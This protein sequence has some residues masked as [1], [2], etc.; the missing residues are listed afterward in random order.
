M[1]DTLLTRVLAKNDATA[2]AWPSGSGITELLS[3]GIGGNYSAEDSSTAVPDG[4]HLGNSDAWFAAPF[5]NETSGGI[6]YY[7]TL[8]F[9]PRVGHVPQLN[10]SVSSLSKRKFQL[11]DG[12]DYTNPVGRLGLGPGHHADKRDSILDQLESDGAIASNTFSLHMGS[13]LLNQSASLIFG[14]YEKNRAL[15]PVGSF[16]MNHGFPMILLRD[17]FLGTAVG[18]TVFENETISVYH[19]IG[20]DKRAALVS[21]GSKL[22]LGATVAGPNP[23][24][25]YIYLPWGTCEAAAKHLP[26]T[27]DDSLGLYLWNVEDPRYNRT[28]GS[29]AYMGFTL[30]D[31][32]AANIT[33]KVP[34]QLLNLTLTPP[35]VE[36]P[37]KYLPCRPTRTE[38]GFFQLGRAFLQSAFM[39]VN[40]ETNTM[41]MAQGP[42]PDMGQ[43]VLRSVD[44]GTGS[45]L[46]TEPIDT[47]VETWA[48][49]WTAYPEADSPSDAIVEL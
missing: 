49:R 18:A 5:L 44:S 27:W 30:E 40:F 26:V 31:Q 4:T 24:T 47:W 48:S 37:T 33:I 32:N 3:T 38:Y 2:F 23:S 1:R 16:E 6:G 17:V 35:L 42:G 20:D 10:A 29:S 14:G 34:F 46:E 22:P 41:M 21:R 8:R 15:G 45:I 13:A 28:V 12:F 7:D 9:D 39:F 19:G 11:L 25:P 43:S 36:I